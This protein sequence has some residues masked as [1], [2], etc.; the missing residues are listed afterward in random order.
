M[1]RR[2]RHV[3]SARGLQAIAAVLLSAV[4]LPSLA[5]SANQQD[6]YSFSI[7]RR[8]ISDLFFLNGSVGWIAATDH[9]NGKCYIWA[10]T[11]GGEDWTKWS[12]PDGMFRI[13]FVS[14]S[15]G[16]ALRQVGSSGRGDEQVHLLRTESGGQAW[17][18]V[19]PVPVSSQ[20][21]TA[22]SRASLAFLD[23]LHGW[24]VGSSARAP[25]FVTSD[26]G[27]TI[28]QVENLPDRANVYRVYARQSQGVWIYGEG[29]VWHSTDSGKLWTSAVNLRALK[30]NPYAFDASDI[31][32]SR[33]GRG[34]IV[35]QDPYGM[36]LETGDHGRHWERVREDEEIGN[37][38]SIWFWD[39]AHGC[40]AGYPTF[41]VC[42][43]DGGEKWV[44]RDVLPSA[45]GNQSE[46]FSKLVLLKS[47]RG[48]LLRLGGYL[49]CT[50]D[51]GQTWRGCDLPN[52]SAK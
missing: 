1:L 12:A 21:Q 41:L 8:E 32:F 47:G 14:P 6:D 38:S 23:D 36:I 24:F 13:W 26:G 20:V 2:R 17:A 31:Y 42:T 30:T 25:V 40:A 4:L 34:W 11:D 16:W 7:D 50:Q 48:W 3:I 51:G 28:H 19:S 18:E 9:E 39:D 49:Y 43:Q 29:F 22:Y 5:R 45:T 37:F 35:G 27:V 46:S 10:T 15:L 33:D 44:T 52:S